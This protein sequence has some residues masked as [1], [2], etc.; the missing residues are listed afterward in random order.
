MIFSVKVEIPKL[1]EVGGV[2]VSFRGYIV[3]V[4]LNLKFFFYTC[5]FSS[6]LGTIRRFKRTANAER[7]QPAAPNRC[8]SK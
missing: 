7:R 2:R 8:R 4:D 1:I 6:I 5:T 3:I